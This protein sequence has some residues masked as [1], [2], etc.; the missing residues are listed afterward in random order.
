MLLSYSFTSKN[1]LLIWSSISFKFSFLVASR[2]YASHSGSNSELAPLA[3]ETSFSITDWTAT[4]LNASPFPRTSLILVFLVTDSF[5]NL[6]YS[7]YIFSVASSCCN[8]D[9]I[10]EFS[11]FSVSTY[12][13]NYVSD[14]FIDLR[15]ISGS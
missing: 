12:L 4:S 3:T 9:I 10:S 6:S 7:N 1:S 15:D 2:L 13:I 14:C 5:S 8:F 11:D